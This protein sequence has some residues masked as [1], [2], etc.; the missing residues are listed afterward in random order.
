MTE[1]LKPLY[2][3]RFFKP[4]GTIPSATERQMNYIKYLAQKKEQDVS[5]LIQQSLNIKEASAVINVNGKIKYPFMVKKRFH[6]RKEV[7][8]KEVIN[9]TRS[10]FL[11]NFQELE[12]QQ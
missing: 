7:E 9:S 1:A 5:D 2:K 11:K 4:H 8:D 10:N 6:F 12:K 3:R